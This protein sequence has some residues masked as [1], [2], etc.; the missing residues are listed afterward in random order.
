VHCKDYSASC[1]EAVG[2]SNV[3]ND[4]KASLL[5]SSLF[6]KLMNDLIA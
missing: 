5:A 3:Q 6:M 2:D 1:I 4:N